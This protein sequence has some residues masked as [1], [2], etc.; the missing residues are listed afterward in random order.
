MISCKEASELSIKRQE[1]AISL[2]HRLQL[3]MHLS[4]CKLCKSFDQQTK[5]IGTALKK[6][7]IEAAYT[8]EEKS[9]LKRKVLNTDQQKSN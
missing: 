6:M 7:T 2:K 9:E 5:W 8:A 4:M 3:W 1:K